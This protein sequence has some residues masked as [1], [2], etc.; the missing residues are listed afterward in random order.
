[1]LHRTGTLLQRPGAWCPL[2]D[3][4]RAAP[5]TLPDSRVQHIILQIDLIAE[6]RAEALPELNSARLNRLA[7][8]L[9]CEDGGEERV[10]LSTLQ[11]H[12]MERSLPALLR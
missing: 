9:G 12:N 7:G 8:L 5:G 4:A 2:F 1:M 11:A 3:L 10:A 6:A